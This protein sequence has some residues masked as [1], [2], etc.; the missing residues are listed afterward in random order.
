MNART[1]QQLRLDVSVLDDFEAHSER[2]D[3]SAA[4]RR[5]AVPTLVVH[6]TADAVVP[7][8]AAYSIFGGLAR[9]PRQLELIAG[10]DHT[11]G[12]QHPEPVESP[13]LLRVVDRACEWL[14][15]HLAPSR[16]SERPAE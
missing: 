9:A 4:L 2:Y 16:N 13:F 8:E 10:A 15:R 6:G 5:L 3:L 14:R 7:H 12:T 11:F 1:H